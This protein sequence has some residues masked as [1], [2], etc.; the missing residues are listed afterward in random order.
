LK[1]FIFIG[2]IITLEGDKDSIEIIENH[3][4]RKANIEEIEQIKYHLNTLGSKLIMVTRHECDYQE[5]ETG[6]F[7][8]VPLEREFWKYWIIE[9]DMGRED[10]SF[11]TAIKLCKQDIT[12]LF[13]IIYN[14]DGVTAG[15]MFNHQIYYNFLEEVWYKNYRK[16]I[17][18]QDIQEIVTIQKLIQRFNGIHKDHLFIKKAIDDFDKI[19][20][21]SKK[22]PFFYVSMFSIIESLLATNHKGNEGNGIAHQLATKLSLLNKRFDEPIVLKDYFKS[23]GKFEKT[24][25]ILYTYRS[26]IAHGDFANFDK[27]L[28]SI[29]SK[30]NAT[31]FVYQLLKKLIVQSLKEPDLVSDLKSI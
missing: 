14:D 30:E 7:S 20:M 29:D 16:T 11:E 3:I 26:L 23:P 27:D 2:D 25:K 8:S 4:L 10:Y 9:K 1:G 18:I 22:T 13:D 5:K 12:R 21:V 31:E 17:T 19:K 24:I 6:H 28:Q 15:R